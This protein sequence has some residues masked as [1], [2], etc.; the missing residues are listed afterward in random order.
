MTTRITLTAALLI[1]ALVSSPSIFAAARLTDPGCS[2]ATLAVGGDGC[3]AEPATARSPRT[4][5]LAL[6]LDTSGSMSGLIDSAKEKLWAIVNELGRAEPTP[7]LRVGLLT[8]G[9]DAHNPE[10]GW[11]QLDVPFTMDLDAVSEQLFSLTTNGGTEYV[12]RVVEYATS[13]L[14]WSAD[15]GALKIVVVAGNESADQDTARRFRDVC[16]GAQDSGFHV[17]AIYCGNPEDGDAP[18][19]RDVAVLG[20]G[21]FATIDMDHGTL[22]VAT[23]FDAD[24]ARLN[25]SLNSTYIPFGASGAAGA[26]NQIAQDSNARSLNSA[27]LADRAATKAGKLYSC[28]WD[29]VDACSAQDVKLEELAVEELPEAMQ[30]MTVAQ[31]KSYVAGKQAERSTIQEEIAQLSAKRSQH[32]AQV[33]ALES[34]DDGNSFDKVLRDAVRSQALESGFTFVDLPSL[35]AEAGV[36]AASWGPTMRLAAPRPAGQTV[37]GVLPALDDC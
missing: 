30:V 28:A 1:A 2:T 19:W 37:A 24:L 32:I 13:Q 27:A 31:R 17:N 26:S 33:V 15:D 25:A 4:I 11:V 12:G 20:S 16:S 21:Y 29:L 23:P 35:Q 6:C 3:C 5:D 34:L 36:E 22:A 14:D 18:G 10:D 9:N 8:Y 7:V